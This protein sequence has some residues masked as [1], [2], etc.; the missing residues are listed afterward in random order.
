[1]SNEN[2]DVFVSENAG[3][4]NPDV[5]VKFFTTLNEDI[6]DVLPLTEWEADNE[7]HWLQEQLL[8]S[9]VDIYQRPYSSLDN[10]RHKAKGDMRDA[11]KKD[12]AIQ[13]VQARDRFLIAT[14]RQERITPALNKLK[15][16]YAE[17]TGAEYRTPTERGQDFAQANE[18]KEKVMGDI[19][20]ILA[21]A[22]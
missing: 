12:N 6:K 11:K 15:E 21:Q 3:S 18:Q 16:L 7:V 8:A 9:V 20:R 14:N 13:A 1:M 4:F 22:A 19:D 17:T 10:Q 2:S 5:A